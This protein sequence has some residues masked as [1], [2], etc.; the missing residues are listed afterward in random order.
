MKSKIRPVSIPI[1]R[2]EWHPWFAWYPSKAYVFPELVWEANKANDTNIKPPWR[3]VWLT[4]IERKRVIGG[5][6]CEPFSF[7]VKR[8]TENS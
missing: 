7:W 1:N 8:T 3:W 2:Y 5:L 4:Y 6:R